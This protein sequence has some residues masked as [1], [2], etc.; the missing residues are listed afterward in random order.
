MTWRMNFVRS[1]DAQK[2]LARTSLSTNPRHFVSVQS[3]GDLGRGRK[4]CELAEGF[5]KGFG[6][7]WRVWYRCNC[8]I[9][10][11]RA[12][13]EKKTFQKTLNSPTVAK[14]FENKFSQAVETSFDFALCLFGFVESTKC[15]RFEPYST[16]FS[17]ALKMFWERDASL[18]NIICKANNSL[19]S[20]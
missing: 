5:V 9:L 2:Q 7:G 18:V 12:I 14:V 8:T 6:A 17:I 4:N 19:D 15:I 16:K 1:K 3:S 10:L 11:R 20:S 13:W